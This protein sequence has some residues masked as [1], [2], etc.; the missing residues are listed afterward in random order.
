MPKSYSELLNNEFSQNINSNTDICRSYNTVSVAKDT[1]KTSS[2]NL[3]NHGVQ[4]LV[5]VLK[6]GLP[7]IRLFLHFLHLF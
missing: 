7:Q 1:G 6:P 5:A 4:S 3:F 2:T